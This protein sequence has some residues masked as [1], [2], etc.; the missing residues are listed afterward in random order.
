MPDLLDVV[1]FGAVQAA[2]RVP[3]GSQDLLADYI[4]VV[5]RHIDDLCGPV[6]YRTVTAELHHG[7]SCELFLLR[8]PVASITSVTENGVALVTGDWYLD[9]AGG[10]LTRAGGITSPYAD[11]Y[12]GAGR[13]NVAVTYVAG[14]YPTTGMV[15][16]VFAS[17]AIMAVKGLWMSQQAI[18]GTTTFGYGGDGIADNADSQGGMSYVLPKAAYMLLRPYIQ[19]RVLV[20]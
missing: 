16:P 10:M 7:G 8:Y 15:D 3:D 2:V 17:A 5:S 14:R 18:N 4:T 9:V 1:T 6:V 12:W 19:R 20:G 13:R 11:W